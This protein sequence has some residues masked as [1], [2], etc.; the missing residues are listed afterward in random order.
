[1]TAPIL[2]P[3]ELCTGCGACRNACPAD[4]IVLKTDCDGFLSPKI[5]QNKCFACKRCEKACPALD[6]PDVKRDSA[7]SVFACWTLDDAIRAN[8]ASGGAFGLYANAILRSGGV[9]FGVKF[10]AD[11]RAVFTQVDSVEGLKDLRSSKYVQA[12]VGTTYREVHQALTSGRFVLFVGTPCQVAGLNGY[13]RRSFDNLF[14]IDLVCHGVPS[15][16]LFH[17]WLDWLE[18]E[19]QEELASVSL[20]HKDPAIPG[21]A[22]R[23]TWKNGEVDVFPWND[24]RADYVTE[25]FLS[26]ASLRASCGSCAYA[27]LPRQGDITLGDFWSL[28]LNVPFERPEELGK[29]VSLCLINSAQ[30]VRLNQLARENGTNG[31]VWIERQLQEATNGNPQLTRP[32]GLHR[33]RNI[34]VADS[35][36]LDY[37]SLREKYKGKLEPPLQERIRAKIATKLQKFARKY[38]RHM[39]KRKARREN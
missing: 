17:K 34:F 13:L 18:Q 22:I 15:P 38:R 12:E 26:N 32:A 7:P 25:F 1:M 29:G 37:D 8:S 14:T 5:D 33:R 11:F 30:G 2:A 10:D 27:T 19:K 21:S 24:D 23:L 39:E 3:F 20:R 28:G 6:K 9:V 16:T 36:A 31:G 4:A 35:V